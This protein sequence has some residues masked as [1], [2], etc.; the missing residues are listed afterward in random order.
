MNNPERLALAV[1]KMANLNPN[2]KIDMSPEEVAIMGKVARET[3]FA[4]LT[5]LSTT[6]PRVQHYLRDITG[7]QPSKKEMDWFDLFEGTFSR[8]IEETVAQR[9]GEPNMPSNLPP[10]PLSKGEQLL[11]DHAPLLD[12][13]GKRASTELPFSPDSRSAASQESLDAIFRSLDAFGAA[14]DELDPD[15]LNLSS[16]TDSKGLEKQEA[17]EEEEKYDD[18][19]LV[20]EDEDEDETTALSNSLLSSLNKERSIEADPEENGLKIPKDSILNFS[21]AQQKMDD[22]DLAGE[23]PESIHSIVEP[24]EA[25]T[26]SH[27]VLPH[28]FCLPIVAFVVI[29]CHVDFHFAYADDGPRAHP[30]VLGAEHDRQGNHHHRKTKSFVI[31]S[32]CLLFHFLLSQIQR[33][34]EFNEIHRKETLNHCFVRRFLYPLIIYSRADLCPRCTLPRR[35]R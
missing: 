12:V 15:T 29:S 19:F 18:G 10:T 1:L 27:K 17:G 13:L 24:M 30:R 25:V 14:D 35:R 34:E 7:R 8:A 3:R 33:I 26:E 21:P 5:D 9:T 23:I 32:S 31:L 2:A 22:V 20:E 28:F 6:D 4:L 11:R 16:I